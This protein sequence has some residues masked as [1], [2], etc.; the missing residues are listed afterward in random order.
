M[1]EKV[2]QRI[3][4]FL[5]NLKRLSGRFFLSLAFC[6]IF[7]T[8][9]Q[10]QISLISDEETEQMLAKIIRPHFQKAGVAYHRNH[11]YLVD[12]PSLNAFVADGNNLFIH[13]GTIINADNYNELAGVIAHETGHIQGGHIL[14]QKLKNQEMQV[15]T[16]AS[17]ILAGTAAAVSGRG[18]AAMAVMLG[19]Q[20]SVL[21]HYTRYRTEEERSADEA[22]MKLLEATSQSPQGMLTFMKKI[23]QQNVLSGIEETPYFRT[24]PITSERIRFIENHLQN[25]TYAFDKQLQEDFIR[26]KAKLFAYL[27]P[28]AKT[29]SAYPEKDTSV[30]AQY[31]RAIAYFKKLDL[32][33]AHALL[34][35]LIAL[36]PNNPYFYELKGQ[37]YLE[38]AKIRPAVKEYQKALSLMPNSALLQISLAQALLEASPLDAEI[39]QAITLLNKANI[40]RPMSFSWL[41]LSR[42][43]GM[44][45]NEAE[46]AYASAEYSYALGAY[47]VAKTQAQQAQKLAK[48][49]KLK[50]RISDLLDRLANQDKKRS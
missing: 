31:A 1:V 49:S 37:I 2:N 43:Y 38:T 23:S 10:A 12:D 32:A 45:G 15:A 16:L 41:L 4:S 19:S 39:K 42:A 3:V 17:A 33:K 46:A 28:V 26:V 40:S 22:A 20:S 8:S 24:H 11:V 9:A 47:E 29:L 27:N 18:D 25:K 30:A 5:F 6:T 14:R 50:L 44:N 34:D 36:E 48:N 13:T 7:T 35:R 21:T